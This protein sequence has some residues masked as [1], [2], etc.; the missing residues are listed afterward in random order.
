VLDALEIDARAEMAR[1]WGRIR[2]YLV[3]LFRYQ[4]IEE[5]VAEEL[6]LL[7]GAEELTALLAVE[8]KVASG[9]YDLVVVDCA[10]T[11]TTLRLV[12]LPEVAHGALRWLLRLQ[13]GLTSVVTPL[14]RGVVPI[15][16]PDAGVFRDAETLLYKKLRRL[17]RRITDVGTSVRLVVTPERMVIEEARRAY[18]DLALFDV[19]ADAV[20]MNRLLPPEAAEEA[21]FR[22]WVA[23]QAERR[24]EVV[25]AFEPLRVLDAPL[26]EDEVTGIQSLC[27]H[28]DELFADVPPEAVLAE[29]PRV[30]F[31]RSGGG[32]R[33]R[34][35]LP[36]PRPENLDV[37]KVE[38]ELVVRARD[39]RRSVLLPRR[40][41]PL[42]LTG[43]AWKDGELVV[44]LGRSPE[45]AGP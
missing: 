13:Q 9:D 14:A 26:R 23:V 36:G 7:P 31:E 15:P 10:P 16:L 37:A 21:F 35:P 1:H 29:A 42:H 3:A 4:G 39:R 19:P 11:D 20:V 38:G 17:H 28:G 41:A 27:R 8:E 24:D 12:T 18:T 40:L 25:Q 45:A 30:R 33:A 43:A 34:W 22:D 44:T 6:A 2:D 5:V 32:Y